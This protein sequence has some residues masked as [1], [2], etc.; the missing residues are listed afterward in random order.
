[1]SS[2]PD[3]SKYPFFINTFNP[4]RVQNS[5]RVAFKKD[6]ADSGTTV[7]VSTNASAPKKKKLQSVATLQFFLIIYAAKEY[8]VLWFS[9]FFN[10]L[11]E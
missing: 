2:S 9:V 6:T 3:G 11:F 4:F 1:L 7:D 10:H 5:E 8:S